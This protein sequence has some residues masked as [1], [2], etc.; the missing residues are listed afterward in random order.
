LL[1]Y[2]NTYKSID[3]NTKALQSRKNKMLYTAEYFDEQ[4]EKYKQDLYHKTYR[5]ATNAEL[6]I[7]FSEKYVQYDPQ[8]YIAT[9]MPPEILNKLK[10]YEDLASKEWDYRHFIEIERYSF[11]GLMS[12]ERINY[13]SYI[14]AKEE[15]QKAIESCTNDMNNYPEYSASFSAALSKLK[16][17]EAQIVSK[18]RAA[19]NY[20]S[21]IHQRVAEYQQKQCDN[22]II[23]SENKKNKLPESRY[24]DNII[25]NILF[26]YNDPG[27][28]YMK[29][30][31]KYE[32]HQT[33]D[34]K[35]W[36]VSTGIFSSEKFDTFGKMLDYFLEKC[37]EINCK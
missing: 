9:F 35:K 33:S 27:V 6:K 21:E 8:N 5:E 32:F 29:N 19:E 13:P 24:Y 2:E 37:K 20:I 1:Q 7:A 15:A 28:I 25:D 3:S 17:C 4:S 11:F 34:G 12:R 22:C 10:V 26:S 18:F 36:K 23:D 14:S 16:R 30:G 31:D